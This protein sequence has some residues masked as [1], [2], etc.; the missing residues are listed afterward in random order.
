MLTIDLTEF[1]EL[2]TERLVLRQLRASDAD[3]MFT[4]R[5]DPEVMRHVNR[6]MATS[7]DDAIALIQKINANIAA[8][9]ALHWAITHKGDDAFIGLI[10]L[11]RMVKEHHYA[12]LGYTIMRAQWGS[13]IASE[14]IAAVVDCGFG[15]LGFHRIEA[16]TRP[17]NAASMRALEKNGFVREG[18]FRENI[19]WNGAFHDSV[20]YGRLADTSC[21]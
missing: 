9:E 17:T 4:M 14:A 11:W 6:P 19:L 12:E 10:G 2:T 15:T 16:I 5:S 21:S 18:Y 20:H 7:V 1:P 3:R 8:N 13:G